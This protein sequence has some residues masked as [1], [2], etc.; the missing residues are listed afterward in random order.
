LDSSGHTGGSNLDNFQRA[1]DVFA[2]SGFSPRR[3]TVSTCCLVEGIRSLGERKLAV[4]L[5]IS[6]ISAD[7]EVRTRIMPITR[8]NPLPQLRQ[9]LL[10]YQGDLGKRITLE[11]VLMAG[12]N[13]RPEDI[14]ALV[15]F[16]QGQRGQQQGVPGHRST[17]V[18]S[19]PRPALPR[20]RYKA[21]RARISF[22]CSVISLSTAS[23]S[24]PVRVKRP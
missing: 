23:M 9:A 2:F 13:D 11:I 10:D 8:S 19:P 7:S 1:I 20:A 16:V 22:Q 18:S 12:I 3:V 5:A 17:H 6:L 21:A 4:R 14:E 24:S 15:R